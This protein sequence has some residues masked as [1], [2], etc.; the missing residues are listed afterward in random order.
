MKIPSDN[1][2]TQLNTGNINGVL[3]E[4][5]NM[6]LTTLGEVRL[7]RKSV[8][9]L[10]DNG[11]FE[12]VMAIVYYNG[13]YFVLTDDWAFEGDLSGNTFEAITGGSGMGIESDAIVCYG[14]VYVTKSTS[15]SRWNGSTW[16]NSLDSY[17]SGYPHVMCVFDSLP[18]YKLAVANAN[19]IETLDSSHNPNSTV[20]SLPANYVITCLSYKNGNLYIGTKEING[21]EAAIFLWNGDGTNAQYKIDVGASWIYSMTPYRGSVACV[22]NEGEILMVNGTSLQQL[23]VFPVYH[24]Q[25]ARWDE[26]NAVRGKVYPRGM[27]AQGDTLYINISGKCDSGFVPEMKSGV[28]CY[29]PETGLY[30]LTTPTTDPWTVDVSVTHSSG[31]FT[32]SATHNLVLGDTVMFTAASGVSGIA[33]TT[34]YYVIPVTA[35]TFKIAGTLKDAFDGNNIATIGTVTTD[36]LHYIRNIDNGNIYEA[37]SGA[38]ALTNYLDNGKYPLWSTDLI[39]GSNTK[40]PSGTTK[41]VLCAMSPQKNNGSFIT[42]HIYTN[43]VTQVWKSLYAFI[44]GIEQSGEKITVKYTNTDTVTPL[45]SGTWATTTVFN[46]TDRRA[47]YS[48]EVGDEMVIVDGSGQGRCVHVTAVIE[49]LR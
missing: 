34:L 11:D 42:Q 39:Y 47:M 38:I 29:E 10:T 14:Y 20:L 16:N 13:N 1:R 24:I 15:L 32:S 43:N 17:T 19:Q 26:G 45:F 27:V 31:V 3:H 33:S 4:T 41:N 22:T 44:Q 40:N 21:G 30:H 36:T 8:A 35:T 37:S 2:W 28:W 18:T 48:I 23:A 5:H 46:T 9:V 6:T 49:V 12:Q 25:G 7:S